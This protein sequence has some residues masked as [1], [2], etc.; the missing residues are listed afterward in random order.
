MAK[1]LSFIFKTNKPAWESLIINGWS[2]TM[3][4]YKYST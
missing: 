2:V 3:K 4:N 1:L